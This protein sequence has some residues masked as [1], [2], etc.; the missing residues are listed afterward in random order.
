M[1][2]RVRGGILLNTGAD[3]NA[4]KYNEHWRTT[5][6][7]VASHAIE[8]ATAELLREHGADPNAQDTECQNEDDSVSS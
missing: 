2:L 3:A 7:D 4:H 5:P 8:A 6:L 1:T